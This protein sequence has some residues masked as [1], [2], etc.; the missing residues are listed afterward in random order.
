L[1]RL[2]ALEWRHP[3]ADVL[4]DLDVAAA[5]AKHEERPEARVG[6]DAEDDLVPAAGHLLDEKALDREAG[7]ADRFRDARQRPGQLLLAAQV[8]GDCPHVALVDEAGGDG[9]DDYG[10]ADLARRR[11]GFLTVLRDPPGGE[12]DAVELEHAEGVGGLEV[13]PRHPPPDL[14]PPP[15]V[16]PGTP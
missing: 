12:R 10:K 3:E 16:H 11:Q 9:L 8:D 7:A 15:R 2:P 13:A 1:Q 6:G 4:E 5:K 14:R